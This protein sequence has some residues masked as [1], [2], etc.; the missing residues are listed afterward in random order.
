MN[1]KT[2]K[3]ETK[4]IK[5]KRN[6]Q[7]IKRRTEKDKMYRFQNKVLM[8]IVWQIRGNKIPHNQ[9]NNKNRE[10]LLFNNKYTRRITSL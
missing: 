1:T 2:Q 5:N 7:G 10:K 4:K 8:S 3:K 6:F 9:N